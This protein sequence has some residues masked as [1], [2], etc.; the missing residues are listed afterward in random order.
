MQLHVSRDTICNDT[1][2]HLETATWPSPEAANGILFG[3][4][5]VQTEAAKRDL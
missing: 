2:R 1:Y 3:A 4:E 5:V